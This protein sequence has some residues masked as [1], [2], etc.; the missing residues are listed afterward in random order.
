MSLCLL[1]TD[2]IK[3]IIA[4]IPCPQWFVLC[5]QLRVLAS[6]VISPLDY[7]S[8]E[9]GSFTWAV[10]NNKIFAVA[11]LLKLHHDRID[12][13]VDNNFAIQYATERGY[14]E[15]VEL[16]LQDN[17]TDPST[18]N[19]FAIRIATTN[20]NKEIVEFLLK[21]KRID[22]AVDNNFVIRYATERGY[23]EIVQLLLQGTLRS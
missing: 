20:G 2:L 18:E 23:K 5:K 11:C 17:R 6:H 16:L 21:D 9:H 15:I 13:S 19:N 8:K 1:P 7:R 3:V 10:R 14:K 22:P 12:P 4:Y